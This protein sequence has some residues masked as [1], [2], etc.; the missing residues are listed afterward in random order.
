[1]RDANGYVRLA[2]R[3]SGP[4]PRPVSFSWPW[5]D[6]LP[7]LEE[8]APAVRVIN[9]ETSITR[10]A[11]FVPGKAVH[12]RMSPDNLPCVSVARPDVCA[13]ANNH[14]LYFG[15]PGLAE[16]LGCL[17]GAGLAAAG[18]GLDQAR[19]RHPV[20]VPLPNGRAGRWSFPRGRAPSRSTGA[21]SSCTAAATVSTTM[22]GSPA[23]RP[24][25][26]T[27]ACCTSRR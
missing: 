8:A 21:S 23:T 9:L 12:Y 6:A 1:M 22:R 4:I 18:A 7:L 11:G 3:A 14:V 20:A 27:C 24:T 17:A 16:T 10:S 2:E 5:G 13:L 15:Q 25:G 26:T 19:A